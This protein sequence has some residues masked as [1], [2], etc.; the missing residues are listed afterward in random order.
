MPTVY[1]ICEGNRARS[2]IAEALFTAWAPP[3]WTAA[4]GG[5]S[6]KDS[7]HP[8]AV[9]LLAEIG[10]D[11][12][13]RRPKPIDVDTAKR[14][15]RVIAMCSLES[16]PVGVREVAEHWGIPDP[17]DMPQERWFEIRDQIA[18]RVKALIREIA[19]TAPPPG[20]PVP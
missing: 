11:W 13:G 18:E 15:A 7:V 2:Q 4:S 10:I 5:T 8:A 12:S 17:A 3:G 19:R 6:P 16:C 14:A 1:F 9:D 20:A